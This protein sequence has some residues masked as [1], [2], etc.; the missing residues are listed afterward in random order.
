MYKLIETIIKDQLVQFLV[1]KHLISTHQHAFIKHHSTASSLSKVYMTGK[2]I[3]TLS[4]VQ[5]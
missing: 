2:L 5:I 1:D 3:S 4:R